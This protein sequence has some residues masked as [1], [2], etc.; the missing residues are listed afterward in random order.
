V[1]RPIQVGIQYETFDPIGVERD[2]WKA[3]DEAGFDNLWTSDHPRRTPSS[4]DPDGPILDGWTALAAAAEVTR[5]IRLGVLVSG[6]LYRHPTM[7]AKIAVTVDHLSDGRVE[8]GLGTGWYQSVFEQYGMPFVES[9]GERGRRLEEACAVLK[10]LWTQPRANF[11]GAYYQLSDAVAEPKPLQ[12]PHPPIVI[13]GRGPQLTLKAAAMHADGWNTSGGRGFEADREAA[14]ALDE[15]CRKFGRDPGAIR[16][17]VILEWPNEREGME[18]AERYAAVGFTE[19]IFAV[20]TMGDD[21]RRTVENVARIGLP[22]L[23]SLEAAA[24]AS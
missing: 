18:F 14:L 22:Q 4:G 20:N 7:L 19:F 8:V 24:A 2:V 15:W 6:N 11:V 1:S 3:A 12:Q 21:V 23:R 13:G 9:T 17:S 16:R 10:A 5:Q